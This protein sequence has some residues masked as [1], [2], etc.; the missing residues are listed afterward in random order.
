M[1]RIP[2]TCFDFLK[3]LKR[4]NNK[5]WMDAN[6]AEYKRNE[7]ALKAFYQDITDGLNTNDVIERTKVFRINRDIRFSKDKTPYN[8]HR[9][10]SFSREGAHRRGGYYL[11]IEPGASA[12]AGGFWG[13]EPADLLR[14]RKEFEFDAEPIRKILA[15][16]KFKEAF[17][18]LNTEYQVKTA[19]KGFSKDDPNIDLIKNKA[20][21]VV[22]PFTDKEVLAPD[23]GENVL[24]HFELLRPYFDYMSEVLTTDLNG[25]SLL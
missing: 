15:E 11:R 2:K 16:P 1:N 20:F 4:N 12:M 7:A 19:P 8:V 14:I 3:A 22:H 5:D 6:R 18:G 13:P 23:F 24:Y 10:V 9:S 25:E 17:G 21:F